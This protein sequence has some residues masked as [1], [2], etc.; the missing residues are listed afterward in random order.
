MVVIQMNNK[1][2]KI[3][4]AGIWVRFISLAIDTFVVGLINIILFFI[5]IITIYFLQNDFQSFINLYTSIYIPII[6]G[7]LFIIAWLFYYLFLV[8]KYNATIGMRLCQIEIRNIDLTIEL[9][10][11]TVIEVITI[12][13]SEEL[14]IVL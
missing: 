6:L 2:H 11:S 7:T 3:K 4:Y 10:L 8:K 1:E 9:R 5:I 12:F 14:P 13:I